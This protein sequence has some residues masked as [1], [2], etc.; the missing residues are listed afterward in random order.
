VRSGS[1]KDSRFICHSTSFV[2]P[3][4]PLT[5]S[6]SSHVEPEQCKLYVFFPHVLK[7]RN[8]VGESP[9]QARFVTPPQYA[10]PAYPPYQT[11][12]MQPNV[13]LKFWCNS[14]L[15]VLC[16][17]R[18]NQ[19]DDCFTPDLHDL[20]DAKK[21]CACTIHLSHHVII[22]TLAL[23]DL[24]SR[25]SLFLFFPSCLFYLFYPVTI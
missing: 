9:P 25:R 22:I 19:Y 2:V 3:R 13:R 14:L 21:C 17:G 6:R 1:S 4:P 18:G 8:F 23:S 7:S 24:V 10:Q 5:R 16:V 12:M 15:P 20:C 11:V